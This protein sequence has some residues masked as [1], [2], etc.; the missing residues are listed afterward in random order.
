MFYGLAGFYIVEDELEDSLDLPSGDFDVPLVIQDRS[1]DANGTLRY[2]ENI[3]EGFLGDTIV[4]NGTVSPR[5]A[6]KRA[7]YRLRFL[8]ASNA[9]EYRLEL[10]SRR[11]S[12]RRRRRA[13][14]GAGVAHRGAA[15]PAER[16]DVVVDFRRF[17]AGAQVQLTNG[18][19]SGGTATVMRFDVTGPAPT[20][21]G[22]R[23]S[24]GRARRSRRRRRPVAGT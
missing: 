23:R 15:G 20:P 7:L 16:V 8:N 9:R 2:T 18:L 4:V 12:S 6:V 14:R 13:A 17:R 10:A 19:G 24:S 22:C 11:W 3:D 1:F 5:F 21:A